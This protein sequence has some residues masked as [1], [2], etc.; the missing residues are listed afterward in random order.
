MENELKICILTI[1][2]CQPK[3]KNPYTR[4][5]FIPL[6]SNIKSE[7]I[8]GAPVSP[9]FCHIDAFNKIPEDIILKECVAKI[10]HKPING[11][12]FKSR[13]VLESITTKDNGTINLL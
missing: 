9:I 1:T 13:A 10:T 5:D 3:D 11:N 12:P 6:T 2:K 4:I 7:N 8:K